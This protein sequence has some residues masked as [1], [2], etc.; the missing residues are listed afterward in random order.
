MSDSYSSS[1]S[2]AAEELSS[3]DQGEYCYSIKKFRIIYC[4]HGIYMVYCLIQKCVCME[5]GYDICMGL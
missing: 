2:V 4:L 1:S 3:C 5:W